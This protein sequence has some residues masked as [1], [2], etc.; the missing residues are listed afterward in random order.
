MEMKN[1]KKLLTPA[2]EAELR[3]LSLMLDHAQDDYFRGGVSDAYTKMARAR[4]QLREFTKRLRM[5]GFDI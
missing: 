2:L 3:H 1:G 5:D 4:E